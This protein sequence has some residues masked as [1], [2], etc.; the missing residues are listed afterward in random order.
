M[1]K[2]K[3]FVMTSEE[4]YDDCTFS[5]LIGIAGNIGSGKSVVSRILRCN[6]FFVYDCDMEASLLM[7]RDDYLRKSLISILGKDCYL[8][9]GTLNK[10]FVSTKIFNDKNL[11]NRVNHLVHNAVKNDLINI[12]T[13]VTGKIFVESAI[14]A[15]SGL[16]RLCGKIWVVDAPEDI[17]VRRIM[18]RNHLSVAEIRKRMN[19][20][21]D[22]LL[23]LPDDKIVKIEN[24]D[25]SNLLK[26]ILTL[27][28]SD[29]EFSEFE[30]FSI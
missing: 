8:S 11:R 27:A 3:I 26:Q 17:R 6:G 9:D 20:Q 19:A 5:N 24:D 29:V 30:I 15:T 7:N 28:L 1:L 4:R 21:K 23:K 13:K 12:A 22:E 25:T 10:F 16:G 14:M 18:I 2:N